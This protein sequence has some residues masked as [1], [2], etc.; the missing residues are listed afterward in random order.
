MINPTP[1][2]EQQEQ[3]WDEWNHDYREHG[4]DEFMQAQLDQAL[5]TLPGVEGRQLRILELGCGNGWLSYEL[6]RHG[7]VTAIDISPASIERAKTMYPNVCFE[8]SDFSELSD[9][10]PYDYVVSADVIAH[11]SDQKSFVETAARYLRPGGVFLLMTQNPFVWHRSSY[12]APRGEGQIRDWPSLPAIRAL[13]R[14]WFEITRVHSIVAG[15]DMGVLRLLNSRVFLKVL[16]T[17]L[18]WRRSTALYEKLRIGREL[19]VVGRRHDRESQ[20]PEQV[21]P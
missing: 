13:M 20:G 8:V 5:Q 7:E 1:T 19:V 21:C 2:T 17:G 3:F 14:P 12:L 11:L 10:G 16:R 15:G 4:R 18:G 6:G 9:P